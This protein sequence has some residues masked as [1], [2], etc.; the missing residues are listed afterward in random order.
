VP[1]GYQL[2]DGVRY[3]KL[4]QEW[5]KLDFIDVSAGTNNSMKSRS[6]HYPV[7]SSPARPL[8]SYAKAIK[9]VVDV[10]VFC[11]GKISDPA[12]AEA[13]LAAGHADMVGMTRAHIAEPSIIRKV[14]EG[15]LQDIRTCIHANEGCFS[16]QQRVGDITC[17]YNPRTGR[18]YM[19]ER[20]QPTE[21]YR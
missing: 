17:V 19:W 18:E 10:P 13:I 6:F 20:L 16:R 4:M 1:D 3:A 14:M 9:E 2:E 8:V 7:I 11:V 21:N 15:R 12:D 5:G